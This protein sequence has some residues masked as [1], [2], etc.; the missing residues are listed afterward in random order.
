MENVY[1]LVVESSVDAS[2]FEAADAF[3]TVLAWLV[4]GVWRK[5]DGSAVEGSIV[6]IVPATERQYDDF[7]DYVNDCTAQEE[8]GGGYR[9]EVR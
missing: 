2:P 1:E 6:R 4:D 8:W 9:S 5:C 7:I 3:S